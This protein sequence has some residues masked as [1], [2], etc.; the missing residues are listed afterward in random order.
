[1]LINKK[2]NNEIYNTWLLSLMQIVKQEGR[3]MIL[4][5]I[6]VAD[7]KKKIAEKFSVQIHFHDGC[8][9]QYFTVDRLTDKLKEFIIAFFA[10]KNLN[11]IFSESGEHFFVEEIL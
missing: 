3:I 8:G 6:E 7:L 10:D 2:S 9:G 4:T 5:L 11:V 1:M